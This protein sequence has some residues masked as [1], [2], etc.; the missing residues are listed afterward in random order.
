MR[1]SVG[2]I[3]P[4]WASLS[5]PSIQLSILKSSL[6]SKGIEAR[7]HYLNLLLLKHIDKQ[8]YNRFSTERTLN[9]IAERFLSDIAFGKS[10]LEPFQS[11]LSHMREKTE[12]LD[13]VLS[14]RTFFNSSESPLNVLYGAGFEGVIEDL[15]TRVIPEY[16]DRLRD[17]ISALDHRVFGI[18]STFNQNVP[19]LAISKIIKDIFPNSLV[20]MG[21]ANCESPMSKSILDLSNSV[22]YVISGEGEETFP[23]LLK[24]I[25][26]SEPGTQSMADI[27]GLIYRTPSGSVISNFENILPVDLNKQPIMD[28]DDYYSQRK[29]YE[30][31]GGISAEGCIIFFESSRGCWWGQNS[32]CTFCGL[33]GKMIK[34]RG[35]DPEKV[36]QE[37]V[38][39]SSKYRVLNF[40]AVDNIL[41]TSYIS[42][43]FQSM[44]EQP[45]DITLF[46]EIKAN[47]N[48]RIVEKMYKAGVR[49]VQPGI[50]SLSD[51]ILKHMRKGSSV[52]T[53]LEILKYCKMYSIDVIWNILYGFPSETEEDFDTQDNIISS[54]YHL[55]PPSSFSLIEVHRFSPY[56]EKTE[57]LGISNVRAR[58]DYHYLYPLGTDVE[59]IA[60]T[61]DYDVQRFEGY[62]LKVRQLRRRVELWKKKYFSQKRP[63]LSVEFGPDFAFVTDTRETP[64]KYYLDEIQSKI[65]SSA[66][67]PI[68]IEKLKEK[69]LA[70]EFRYPE[71]EINLEL[72]EKKRLI[73]ANGGKV[74]SLAIPVK[75]VSTKSY[76]ENM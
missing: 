16:I 13:G 50:E 53:N 26:R 55:R 23:L 63:R 19:A 54:I 24:R 2:L 46:Y 10:N 20:I 75:Y 31:P 42:S 70:S 12:K 15:Q 27:P 48:L 8:Q 64:I 69:L 58:S 1:E 41:N 11:Y 33:N 44:S 18:T 7:T 17:Y 68:Y 56:F 34:Y 36:R 59:K 72:L 67:T 76:I 5:N 32:H 40:M 51:K 28:C 35:K 9:F 71:S 37:L 47:M 21:G 25:F 65:L 30:G 62:E 39:L 74:L 61:F 14:F 29:E 6:A 4:P 49:G 22:D 52:M 66:E 45:L 60:Y 57:N 38:H 3:N 43:L 73:Y